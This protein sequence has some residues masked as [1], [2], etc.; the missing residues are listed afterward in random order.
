MLQALLGITLVVFMVGSLL[1][2]GLRLRLPGAVRALR[3]LRFVGLS[4]LWAFVVGPAFAVLLTKVIP[5]AEPYAVGMLFLGMAPCA[6]FLPLV[7]ERARGDLSYVAALMLLTAVGTVVYMPLLTPVLV[8]GFTADAWTIAKPLVLYVT[9]PMALGIAVR[10]AFE[11]F[12]E[13]AHPLVKKV[14]AIDTVIMIV[15]LAWLYRADFAGAIGTYAIA[16][17]LV[18]YSVVAAAAYALAPGLAHSQKSVLALGACTRNLGAA[19]APL[20]TVPGTDPRTIA[21]VALA[22]PLSVLCA[23]GA[24]HLLARRALHLDRAA[25]AA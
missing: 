14:T 2:V 6:P 9:L 20:V 11:N 15:I 5:L 21:M 12:A 1:E 4:V 7:S 17:Q 3:N 25:S 18:F 22:V 10:R 16:T 13:T 24:A 8:K 19:F 23:F